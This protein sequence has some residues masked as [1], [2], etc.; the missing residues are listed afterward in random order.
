MVSMAEGQWIKRARAPMLPP[1]PWFNLAKTTDDVTEPTESG[2][3]SN[4]G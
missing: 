1:M 4:G 2:G 3:V